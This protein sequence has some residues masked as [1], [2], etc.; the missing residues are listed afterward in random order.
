MRV[1]C[2]DGSVLEIP[3]SIGY[4]RRPFA[5]WGGLLRTLAARPLRSAHLAGLAS[6]LGLV[7]RIFLSPEMQSDADM[8]TLSRCLTDHGAQHL[9]M[10]FHSPSLRPGLSPYS[11]GAADV[12][13]L[14]RRIASYVDQL[15]RI[16]PVRF[17]T[18]SE[19]GADPQAAGFPA[20]AALAAPPAPAR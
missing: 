16:T 3:M 6:R 10:F 13:R 15:A 20:R 9:H 18:L 14:Y 12:D 8:L 4:S 7:R 17:V 19:A 5:V 1:P 2:P 11:V